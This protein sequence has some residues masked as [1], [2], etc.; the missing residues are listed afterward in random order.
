MQL[1][2]HDI[3]LL[4]QVTLQNVGEKT[5]WFDLKYDAYLGDEGEGVVA[6]HHRASGRGAL[7]QVDVVVERSPLRW[8]DRKG[9]VGLV[10]FQEAEH[11]TRIAAQVY[12]QIWNRLSWIK[13][14]ISFQLWYHLLLFPCFGRFSSKL[15][16]VIELWSNHILSELILI[17]CF[18]SAKTFSPFRHALELSFVS[19]CLNY[20]CI[21]S[22][23]WASS[24]PLKKECS[25]SA[26]KVLICFFRFQHKFFQNLQL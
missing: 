8:Q 22:C 12:A 9:L 7:A 13:N 1:R 4:V 19:Y 5:C 2:I 16:N 11:A 15:S 17:K 3:R 23:F 20:F 26:Q 21:R 14:C 24:I 25:S 18:H 6:I 10:I